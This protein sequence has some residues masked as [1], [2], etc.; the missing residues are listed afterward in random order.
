MACV[1]RCPRGVAPAA[2]IEAVR[3]SVIRV[4]GQN[5]L[6]AEEVPQFVDPEFPQQILVSAFRKYN[7]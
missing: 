6:K 1:E 7:R 2:V 3:E 4:Q 5:Q